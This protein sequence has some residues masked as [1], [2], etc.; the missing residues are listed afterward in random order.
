MIYIKLQSN[1]NL[2]VIVFSFI[3]IIRDRDRPIK[4]PKRGWRHSTLKWVIMPC[5]RS[6]KIEYEYYVL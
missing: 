4:V 2:I 6:L 5:A 1:N 3:I